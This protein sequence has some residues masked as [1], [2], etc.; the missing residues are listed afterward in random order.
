MRALRV[1][2]PRPPRSTRAPREGFHLSP[3]QVEF[4]M[5]AVGQG[6]RMIALAGVLAACDS[7]GGGGGVEESVATTVSAASAVSQTAVASTIAAEAPSVKVVDQRGAAMANV[8][9]AFTASD[10]G[11]VA[12]PTAV[13]NASGVATAGPW[14]LSAVLGQQA[15]TA[16]VGSLAPVQF[17]VMS[18]PRVATTMTAVSPATQAALAGAVVAA[19]PTVRVNDQTGAPLASVR[20]TF[21]VTGGGTIQTASVMTGADGTASS[22]TWR[23]GATPGAN[24]VSAAVPGLPPVVFSATGTPRTATTLAAVSATTQTG[25]AGSAAPQTPTVQVNDE[26]GAPLAGVGVLFMVAG[27]GGTIQ[28]STAVTGPDGRASSGI[29][30]LG[31]AAGPN[32]VSATVA[33]VGQVLFSATAMARTA[34]SLQQVSPINQP[35]IVGTAVA[36]P[37][38]VRVNDQAG[39]PLAGVTVTFAVTAGGGSIQ[40]TT[41]TTGADGRATAGTWTLGPTAGQNQVTASVAG[42][43]P[44]AFTANGGVRAPTTVTAQ[45][46]TTQTAPAG[47]AVAAPPSVRVTDQVGQPVAGVAVTFAVTGGGGTLTGGSATTNA[48]GIA[49]VASWTLGATPGQNT[50]TAT[51]AGLPPVTFTATGTGGDPCARTTAYTLGSTVNGSLATTDCRV[52]SGEYL[53]IYTTTLPAAQAVAFTM[54]SAAVDPWLELYDGSG[55]I[56]AFN[57]DGTGSGTAAQIKVFAPAGNYFLAASSYEPSQVGA[58]TLSSAGFAGNV[59]CLEYWVV[60]GVVIS[61]TVASSDCNFEGYLTDEYLVILRPGQ[62]LTVR[63][64]SAALDAYLQ[65]YNSNGSVVAEDDDSAGGTNARMVYTYPSS[66]TAA[67]YFFIDASTVGTGETGAYTLT[68]TRN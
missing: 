59:N 32:A 10:G 43:S 47:T 35:G 62:T 55:N 31:P 42:I 17:T 2:P 33:G 53:D 25:V 40:N 26:T 65:M 49:A 66:A 6:W 4:P 23:L 39:V 67:A 3:A 11:S 52:S 8:A 61:G 60:P 51:A 30:M 16:T 20:V 37:P 63:M 9:V 12:S 13:T 50:V 1:P 19:A 18:Q 64:E 24:T 45:S 54:S 46:V 15:V 5:K 27:G 14:T 41:A 68:I 44:V 48:S 58:Y 36:Q 29:W 22:G 38:V 21:T 7:G 34:T 56:A 28:T 57:D